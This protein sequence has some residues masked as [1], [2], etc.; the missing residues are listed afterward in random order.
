MIQFQ[1]KKNPYII[2]KYKVNKRFKI[3][4]TDEQHARRQQNN[5]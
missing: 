3:G 4:E 5:Q 2:S 1:M